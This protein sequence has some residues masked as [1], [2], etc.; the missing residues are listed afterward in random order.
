MLVV[1]S[2]VEVVVMSGLLGGVSGAGS[3]GE[4]STISSS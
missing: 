4:T 2:I 3:E 1:K